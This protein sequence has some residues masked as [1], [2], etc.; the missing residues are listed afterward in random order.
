MATFASILLAA[1]IS[2]SSA[3]SPPMQLTGLREITIC[4]AKLN[5]I[6]SNF[7]LDEILATEKEFSDDISSSTEQPN[8]GR[9]RI[10]PKDKKRQRLKQQLEVQQKKKGQNVNDTTDAYANSN[11]QAK[12]EESDSDIDFESIVF[13]SL[14]VSTSLDGKRV[15]AVLADLL[16][17]EASDESMPKQPSKYHAH[18]VVYFFP[19]S[20][21]LSFHL[22]M[23]MN[24]LKVKSHKR[25]P[26]HLTL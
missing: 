11:T 18:S 3:F 5:K 14:E 23:Q 9:S 10:R 12:S 19:T 22:M 7:D 17:N 2:T 24:L 21:Y 26:Y 15:D 16:N 6:A 1:A 13:A 4:N 25:Y 20:A 8:R